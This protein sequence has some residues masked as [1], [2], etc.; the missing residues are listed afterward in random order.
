MSQVILRDHARLIW[1]AA[2]AAV[3]ANVLMAGAIG[4]AAAPLV[5]ALDRARRIVVV[6]GGKAGAAMSAALEDALADRLDRVTGVVNVPAESVRPL[7]AVRLHAARPAGSNE[8]TAEGVAGTEQIL[9][10]VGDAGPDD[11]VVCLL[12]GGGSALMPAP[13][14]GVMLADKQAV[15]RLL[16][17]CGATIVEMNAVRKHLSRVK[18]GGL[19]VACRAGHLFCLTISDVVGDPL[20]VISSGPTAPD[21]TT[22]EDALAVLRRY[23]LTEKVP[24][25][26]RLRLERGAAGELP[27]TLKSLPPAVHNLVIGNNATALAA[28]GARAVGLGYRVVNLGAFI[29]G[30]TRHVAAAVAGIARSIAADGEPL[31]PPACLLLGGET[32]VTLDPGHGKGGRNTEFVLAAL[33]ALAPTPVRRFVVLSGG[34]DGEDG[35]TDAAGAVADPGTIDRAVRLG[36]D[37]ADVLRAHDSYTFFEATGDLIVT[38]LTDTNVMDVRIV[39]VGTG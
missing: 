38:G 15:T 30:E 35:P 18:G 10:L 6:G 25:A 3:R 19:A 28:A 11:V 36:L 32:T 33:T 14:E 26:V 1:D 39:L 7:R 29:E 16:H 22:Y 4:D 13:A 9:R 27:E 23:D 31:A 12:S 17:A 2:V 20:D 34:T 21:P 24:T 8:P 37:P 5:R